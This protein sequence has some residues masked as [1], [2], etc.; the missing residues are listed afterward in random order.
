MDPEELY[1][2]YGAGNGK[3]LHPIEEIY[4]IEKGKINKDIKKVWEKAKHLL[5]NAEDIYRVYKYLRDRGYISKPVED[6]LKVY[7]KGFRPGEDRTIYILKVN[8]DLNKMKEDLKLAGRLRKQLIYAFVNEKIEFVKI[9]R[10]N[11]E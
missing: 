4:F 9:T 6:F 8:P 1:R 3:E 2:L 5:K 7:K 11:F 10:T